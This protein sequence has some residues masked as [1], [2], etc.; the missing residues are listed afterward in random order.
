MRG[1]RVLEQIE[2]AAWLSGLDQERA[3][4]RAR[5]ALAEARLVESARTPSAHLSGGQ[6]R[7]LG[8]A[9]VLAADADVLVLD[10][11][12]ARVRPGTPRQWT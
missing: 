1:L 4:T 2:Y 3:Q 8:L 10:E 11:P 6:L 9:Q 12:T 7:R 5:A